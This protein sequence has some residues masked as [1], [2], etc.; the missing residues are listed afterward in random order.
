MAVPPLYHWYVRG[1]VPVA[2]TLKVAVW[3]AV[4]VWLAGGVVMVGAVFTV[5]VAGALVADPAVL[6]TVTVKREP[7]SPLTVAGV[8]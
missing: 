6:V 2:V 8:V 3:P 1:P 7:L 5:R 4:T